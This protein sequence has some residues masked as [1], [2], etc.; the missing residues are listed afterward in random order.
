MLRE[1]GGWRA[2][3]NSRLCLK[4]CL[5]GF[6]VLRTETNRHTEERS[7][8]LHAAQDTGQRDE[9]GID[10]WSLSFFVKQKLRTRARALF[11]SRPIRIHIY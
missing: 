4:G 2:A 7:H 3:E 5:R 6:Q 10:L 8:W 11:K 9:L 1:P